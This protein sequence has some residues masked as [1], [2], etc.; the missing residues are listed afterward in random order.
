MHLC[1]QCTKQRGAEQ[2][3]N[4]FASKQEI[5]FFLRPFRTPSNERILAAVS[6]SNIFRTSE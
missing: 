5:A 1:I 3:G 4:A 6:V 2:K